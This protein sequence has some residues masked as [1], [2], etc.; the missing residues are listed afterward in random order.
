MQDGEDMFT[1]PRDCASCSHAQLA[2]GPGWERRS[3]YIY[4]YVLTTSINRCSPSARRLA[5]PPHLIIV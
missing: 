3:V 4:R 5:T 2:L 1:K